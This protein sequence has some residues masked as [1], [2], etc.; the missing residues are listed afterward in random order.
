MF[1]QDRSYEVSPMQIL[2]Y[3]LK[4]MVPIFW[5]VSVIPFYM[6]WV[7]ATHKLFPTYIL[8]IL[9]GISSTS[10]KLNEFLSFGFGFLALG[11]FLGGSTLLYNDYWDSEV[12]KTSRR[13]G[14]FPLP[15]GLLAP[16]TVLWTSL[17]LMSLALLF[18]F[19]VSFLFCVLVIFCVVLSL[20][21]STPPV[22]LKNRAGLDVITNAF[23]SGL[24][25]SIAGWIVVKPFL[26]YPWIWGLTSM[27]GVAAIYIP[28]TIIDYESDMKAK[29]MTFA[30][31]FGRNKA[32]FFG[33]LSVAMAN[34]LI[35]YMGLINYLI[36][37]ELVIVIWPIALAQVILYPL[38][39]K[40]MTF[41]GVYW[42]ILSLSLLLV[43]GNALLLT[44]Y[45]GWWDL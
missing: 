8:D 31:R 42:T 37:P 10:D 17:F 30:V 38:I 1:L 6:G 29:E 27:N 22:R 4:H 23:G 15:Q 19:F 20:A 33:T 36:T 24:L 21:Y 35:I 3:I 43:L 7:F 5:G 26:E 14:L 28:T 2:R 32:F 9:T 45:V 41:K 12:D 13:K 44:Y 16:K 25:C 40:R 34:L 39:L 18:S 11:P